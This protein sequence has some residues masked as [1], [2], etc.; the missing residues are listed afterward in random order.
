MKSYCT[1]LPSRS[2]FSFLFLFFLL[3]IE[4]FSQLQS[5]ADSAIGLMS[6]GNYDASI[7]LLKASVK[8]EKNA[9]PLWRLLGQVYY[10]AKKCDDAIDAY[11]IAGNLEGCDSCFGDLE[12]AGIIAAEAGRTDLAKLFLGI[13]LQRGSKTARPRLTRVYFDEGEDYLNEKNLPSAV[14]AFSNALAYQQDTLTYQRL[15]L[16]YMKGEDYDKVIKLGTYLISKFSNFVFPHILI[17]TINRDRGSEFINNDQYE[18]AIPFFLTAL[19]HNPKDTR[20]YSGLGI[21]YDKLEDVARAVDN[22]KRAEQWLDI[23]ELYLRIGKLAEAEK[24]LQHL[25]RLQID[26]YVAWIL[27]GKV[28]DKMHNYGKSADCYGQAEAVKVTDSHFEGR[29]LVVSIK[30]ERDQLPSAEKYP[31]LKC[32]SSL[33]EQDTLIFYESI[34]APDTT[35]GEPPDNVKVESPPIPIDIPTIVSDKLS[36]YFGYQGVVWVKLWV[37][38]DGTVRKAVWSKCDNIAFISSAI[39]AGLHCKFV[40]AVLNG[41]PAD[42]WVTMPFRFCLIH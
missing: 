27:L 6:S 36:R 41:K 22:Y 14:T 26:D 15:L 33:P 4:A 5:V 32:D 12:R 3:P 7:E 13:T 17:A 37:T 38:S 10:D 9:A 16:C 40:P 29:D 2:D 11:F 1:N 39:D 21:C 28:Y 42:A 31:F 35:A 8:K 25:L 18:K 20:A 30:K 24:L 34:Y 19:K 23:A